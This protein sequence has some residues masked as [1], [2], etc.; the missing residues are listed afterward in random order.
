[1]TSH[2]EQAF[3]VTAAIS[4]ESTKEYSLTLM[5]RASIMGVMTSTWKRELGSPE[6]KS[7]PTV[8]ASGNSSPMI[9]A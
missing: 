6:Q 8:L 5:P 3:A 1:M 2:S 4:L 7:I 9:S